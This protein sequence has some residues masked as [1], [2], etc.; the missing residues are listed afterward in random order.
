MGK[1]EEYY[2]YV[3]NRLVEGC[4][5]DSKEVILPPFSQAINIAPH[6]LTYEES[7]YPTRDRYD[8]GMKLL[9]SMFNNYVRIKYAIDGEDF[10]EMY[11]IFYKL[12]VDKLT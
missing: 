3:A 5:I 12:M 4:T 1:K 8:S 11:D 6:F 9:K 7:N 10:Y 2:T